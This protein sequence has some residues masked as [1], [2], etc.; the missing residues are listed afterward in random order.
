MRRFFPMVMLVFVVACAREIVGP[1]P[2]VTVLGTCPTGP[3]VTLLVNNAKCLAS[4]CDSL[5]VFAYPSDQPDT[6]GGLWTLDLGVMTTPRACFVLPTSAH[7]YVIGESYTAPPD[8][9]VTTWTTRI[10][11]SLAAGPPSAGFFE[12]N[13]STQAFIPAN[14]AGWS[15][16]FPT[17]RAAL[18]GA[19][20]TP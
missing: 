10:P 4:P 2:A 18:P 14:A 3:C 16:T 11:L 13:P 8:T 9:S 7:F 5:E 17:D 20:C 6:P 12:P 1:R 15:I 19:S